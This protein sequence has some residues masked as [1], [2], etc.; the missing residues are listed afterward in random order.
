MKRGLFTLLATS[1][2]ATAFSAGCISNEPSKIEFP[3]GTK[4]LEP[5]DL[6]ASKNTGQISQGDPDMHSRMP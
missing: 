6:K 3:P 2:V 4:P 1:L 5:V